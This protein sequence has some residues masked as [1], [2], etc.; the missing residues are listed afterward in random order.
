MTIRAELSRLS[1]PQIMLLLDLRRGPIYRQKC[2]YRR[3]R[4]FDVPSTH[5]Y[6]AVDALHTR[7]GE[8]KC[9]HCGMVVWR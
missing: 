7:C 3:R 9:V 5:H 6:S 2:G 1:Q 4:I 8:T